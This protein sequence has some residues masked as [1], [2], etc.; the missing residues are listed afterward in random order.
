MAAYY[1]D[2]STAC[3]GSTAVDK[4]QFPCV[5][6]DTK[7]IIL[8]VDNRQRETVTLRK[9]LEFSGFKTQVAH[10]ETG[11]INKIEEHPPDIVLLEV[12]LSDSTARGSC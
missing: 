8:I 11:A 9:Q 10:T 4:R 6:T 12:S 3:S 7:K 2:I 1:L 5:S